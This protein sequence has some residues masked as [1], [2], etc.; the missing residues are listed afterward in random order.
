MLHEEASSTCLRII[1]TFEKE[2][3]KDYAKE[4][5]EKAVLLKDDKRLLY[6]SLSLFYFTT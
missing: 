2:E 1:A 6:S 5:E 3:K 4:K